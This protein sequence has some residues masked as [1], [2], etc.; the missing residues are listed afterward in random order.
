MSRYQKL[1]MQIMSGTQDSN[2]SFS[3]LQKI[4]TLLGFTVRIKGDHFIYFKDGVEEIINIQPN[5]NKAKPYQ[6]KQ[7]RNIILKYRMGGSFDV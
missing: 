7:V 6:V 2:I 1:Y 5:G 4:L 3:D